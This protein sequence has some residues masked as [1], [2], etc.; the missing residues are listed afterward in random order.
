M[1]AKEV[2]F[3]RG[4]DP[5]DVLELGNKNLRAF[6]K[7]VDDKNWFGPLQPLIRGLME[8]SIPEKEAIKFIDRGIIHYDTR[9]SL[10][11]Y[12]DWEETGNCFWDKQA[13]KLWIIFEMPP[14]DF[15]DI[16]RYRKIYCQILESENFIH[17]EHYAIQ[18]YLKITQDKGMGEENFHESML[19]YPD[20]D[21]FKISN[22]IN[23]INKTVENTIKYTD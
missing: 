3:E 17:R 18:S 12:K 9:R 23:I 21:N 16:T 20:D 7:M 1:R 14:A 10:A 13:D 22:I 19:F 2:S 5:K 6:R 15:L 8:G 11:W 4:K